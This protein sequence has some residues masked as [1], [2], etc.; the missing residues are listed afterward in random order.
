M[1]PSARPMMDRNMKIKKEAFGVEVF[2]KVVLEAEVLTG[3]KALTM[4]G[5]DKEIAAAIDA[6]KQKVAVPTNK[7]EMK[8]R[9]IANLD[10]E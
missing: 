4:S 2:D 7:K 1:R 3:L 8:Q 10:I 9:E 6:T 5:V